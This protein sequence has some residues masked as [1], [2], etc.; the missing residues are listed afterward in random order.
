MLKRGGEPRSWHQ[1]KSISVANIKIFL[2]PKSKYCFCHHAITA[3]T[4]SRTSSWHQMKSIS[5]ANF[6]IFLS[7]KSKYFFCHHAIRAQ[8][9]RRTTQL[10]SDEK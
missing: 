7:P 9:G 4:G 5:V 3:Q 2:L 10:A 6:K 1:M 8:T